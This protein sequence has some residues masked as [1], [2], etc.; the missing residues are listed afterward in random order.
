MTIIKPDQCVT[1]YM[2][3]QVS[4]GSREVATVTPDHER[5][6]DR[7]PESDLESFTMRGGEKVC[8]HG[9]SY[10]NAI[11]SRIGAHL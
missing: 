7:D 1:V 2:L 6:R 11:L 3:V 5:E 8:E 9:V 4:P 10:I